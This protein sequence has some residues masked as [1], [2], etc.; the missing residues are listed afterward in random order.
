MLAEIPIVYNV[1]D[2]FLDEVP[3]LLEVEFAIDLVLNV[4]LIFRDPYR[5]APLELRSS[6]SR[7]RS[8]WIRDLYGH[9]TL[10][11]SCPLHQEEGQ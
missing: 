2:I 8:Y 5:M 6:S 1:A 3:G 10:G 11:C 9:L 7:C 4:T